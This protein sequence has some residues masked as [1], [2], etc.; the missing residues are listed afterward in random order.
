VETS[1]S[2]DVALKGVKAACEQAKGKWSAGGS[3]ATA[4]I[5]GSCQHKTPVGVDTVF[6]YKVGENAKN[7]AKYQDQC[8]KLAGTWTA[9]K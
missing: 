6:I 1:E 9:A 3:C 8:K 4:N 2:N 5:L 7:V